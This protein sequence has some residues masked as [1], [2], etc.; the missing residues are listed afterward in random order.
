MNRYVFQLAPNYGWHDKMNI[1]FYAI[2]A[3]TLEAAKQY[4]KESQLNGEFV[5]VMPM[6]VIKID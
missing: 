5:G 1:K 2:E 3:T 4:S 6:D